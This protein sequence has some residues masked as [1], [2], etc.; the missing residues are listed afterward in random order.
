LYQIVSKWNN[1]VSSEIS[2]QALSSN[3]I[4]HIPV[5]IMYK[6]IF[7]HSF[8]AGETSYVQ[9]ATAAVIVNGGQKLSL[10]PIHLYCFC[11]SMNKRLRIV[12]NYSI[13][14]FQRNFKTNYL[15]NDWE[16][17]NQ[18]VFNNKTISVQ[19]W[20]TIVEELHPF[21]RPTWM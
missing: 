20:I 16:P 3:C 7:H 10:S 6:Y 4:A 11:A 5:K 17:G 1:I 13:Q 2:T 18:I 15:S 19:R 9:M 14:H 8:N 21:T 12:R